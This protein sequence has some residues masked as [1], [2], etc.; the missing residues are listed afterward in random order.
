M[1]LNVIRIVKTSLL[2]LF[3]TVWLDGCYRVAKEN[4]VGQSQATSGLGA[5]TIYP[6]G[7]NLDGIIIYLEEDLCQALEWFESN[8][9]VANPSKFQMILHSDSASDFL[10]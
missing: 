4:R 6:C 8:R 7:A 9:L 10:K 3:R 1:T 5:Y 2:L